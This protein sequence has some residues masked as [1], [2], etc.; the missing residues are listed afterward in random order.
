M[1]TTMN[2]KHDQLE[3]I[4]TYLSTLPK[5]L[6]DIILDYKRHSEHSQKM[7]IPFQI[8]RLLDLC[9]YGYLVNRV[10]SPKDQISH[11]I[12]NVCQ[13]EHNQIYHL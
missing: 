2:A 4:E 7:N 3:T 12:R 8:I 13:Y 6:E 1:S 9:D 5:V 10:T 11:C